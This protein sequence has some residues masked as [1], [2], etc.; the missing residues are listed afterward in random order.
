MS[1]FNPVRRTLLIGATSSIFLARFPLI[2]Q[3]QG[4]TAVCSHAGQKIIFSGKHYLCKK[5]NGKLRWQPL[6][7]LKPVVKVHPS[8]ATASAH[9]S[10]TTTKPSGFLVTKL[11]NLV[12]GQ[13]KVV[14]AKDLNGNSVGIALFLSGGVV[15]AHSVIC[16]HQGCIVAEMGKNLACP[17]H[18]SLFNGESGAVINGPAQ[19]SLNAFKVAEVN[20]DI[21]IIS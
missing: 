9:P 13:A 20:G 8:P 5:I 18:G 16:T 21:Y 4:P 7:P 10:E 15:T 17:C 3:A 19:S 2:A 14:T 12:D 11:S 1:K 6:T